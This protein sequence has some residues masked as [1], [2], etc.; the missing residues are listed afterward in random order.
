MNVL[1]VVAKYPS[2]ENPQSGSFILSQIDSLR[3]EGISCG[4]CVE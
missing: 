2:E 3:N 4:V 1:Q